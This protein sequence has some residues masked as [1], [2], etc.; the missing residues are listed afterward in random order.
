M[1]PTDFHTHILPG[2]DDGSKS[3]EESLA[4]LR[5]EAEQGITRVMAT[6]HFYAH[7][8]N[9]D[10][11]LSRRE[12][13]A[14]QLCEAMEGQKGLPQ[15]CLGAEVY[16]FPGIS[17]SEILSRMAFGENKSILIEM[18]MSPWTQQMYREL[19]WISVKQGLTPVLAHLD[20]YISPFRTHGILKRL[21]DLPVL[22][23]ANASFFLR[24]T[25]V[26]FATKLLR[27]NR[28][29]LLGSDCHN[30]QHRPPN[31]GVAMDVITRR[32]GDEILAQIQEN[33]STIFTS[34]GVAV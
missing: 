18:P 23:Q 28:I 26:G 32:C 4:M 16:Y 29:H 20:R 7:H 14:L 31:V 17:N 34:S 9:P 19:E 10:Q 1:M 13:A 27:Q 8:D 22:V 30:T 21:E 3:V 6:S 15:V 25:T 2:V 11:F 24:R 12:A 5:M 33:E